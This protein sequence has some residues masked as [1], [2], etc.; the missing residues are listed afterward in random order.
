VEE[1]GT[2][3][4]FVAFAIMRAFLPEVVRVTVRREPSGVFVALS[5]D[6]PGPLAVELDAKR[7]SVAVPERIQAWFAAEGCPVRVTMGEGRAVALSSWNVM[8]ET[9]CPGSLEQDRPRG[10]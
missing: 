5:P 6:L 10:P 2:N 9:A 8:P 1:G 3:S 7:L 4:C